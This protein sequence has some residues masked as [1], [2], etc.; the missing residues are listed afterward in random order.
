[1]LFQV[2]R[3]IIDKKIKKEA[4]KNLGNLNANLGITSR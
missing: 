2:S 1:M 3:I 4:N